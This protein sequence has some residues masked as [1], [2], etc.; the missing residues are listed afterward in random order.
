LEQSGASSNVQIG[1]NQATALLNEPDGAKDGDHAKGDGN[2]NDFDPHL[3]K[4][5]DWSWKMG[6]PYDA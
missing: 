1:A 6:L 4:V 5:Y 2:Q 3:F